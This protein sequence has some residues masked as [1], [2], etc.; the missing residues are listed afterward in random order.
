MPA[1]FIEVD[2][3]DRID[4]LLASITAVPQEDI[5]GYVLVVMLKDPDRRLITGTNFIGRQS[6]CH[7]LARAANEWPPD[8]EAG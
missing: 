6:V 5:M 8:E 1:F 4:P 7:V 3:M 2:G